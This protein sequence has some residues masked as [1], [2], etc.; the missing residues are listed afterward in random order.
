MLYGKDTTSFSIV[1]VRENMPVEIFLSALPLIVAIGMLAVLRRS[2]LQTSIAT[3]IVAIILVLLVPSLRLSPLHLLFALGNG[4][5]TS[6]TVLFILFPALLLYQL[7]QTRAGMSILAQGIARL[8]PDRDLLVLAIV[9]GLAPFAEAVSGFGVGTVVVIPIL[10]AVGFDPMQAAILGLLGQF[11]VPWGG[12]AVGT[13]I[14]SQL[15]KLDPGIL[16]AS[17]ALITVPFPFLFG[18]VALYMSGRW[19]AIRH[20]WLICCITSFVVIAGL[21]VFSFVPGIELAAVLACLLSLA[22]LVGWGYVTARRTT[23]F[24]TTTDVERTSLSFHEQVTEDTTQPVPVEHQASVPLWRVVAPYALLVATLLLTRLIIPLR[25]WLQTRIVLSQPAIS[26]NL[27]VLYNPGALLLLSAFA[28]IPLLHLTGSEALH[29]LSKT[30]KQFLPGAIAILCFLIVSQVMSASGMTATLGA[31]AATFGN[32]YAWIAPWLGALGGWLTGSN[33]GGNAM[34]ALLQKAVSIRI[35]LPLRW[36]MAAQN[37]SGSVAT[38]VSPA[39]LILAA[40]A[41]GLLG[42][43]SY[44]LRRVG[45]LVLIAVALVMVLLVVIVA[46]L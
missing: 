16:G 46:Y 27:P 33:T 38:M 23:T 25:D 9:L 42:K 8:C 10:I 14:G 37:G 6:L 11:A 12:L 34:F 36:I 41:A 40:T 20:H 5:S 22:L 15:T 17:T 30:W 1:E 45:P 3:L 21:W 13:V 39:R 44:L 19:R 35:G 18:F 7:E 31:A 43:E 32:N 28:T 24:V 26:L 29:T 2:G 4:F